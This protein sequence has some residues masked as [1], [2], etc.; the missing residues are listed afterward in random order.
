VSRLA[1]TLRLRR[2]EDVFSAPDVDPF[3]TWYQAYSHG[4]AIDYVEACVADH[5]EKEHVDIVVEL[6][7]ESHCEEDGARLSTAL[8]RY[9]DARLVRLERESKRNNSRGWLMLAFTIFVVAFFVFLAHRL[10]DSSWEALT[11]AAE[12]LSIAAWVLLWHPL[13]A[14]VF[15]RWDFR[16]DRRVLRTIRDRATVR[17]DPLDLTG[18][19]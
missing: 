10:Q 8:V 9:C 5:P 3:S 12:G 16:L 13:E 15:N 6:P 11:I 7:R 14:L 2:L 17:V 4:P 19:D 18:D 1:V